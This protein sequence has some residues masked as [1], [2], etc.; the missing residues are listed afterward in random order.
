MTTRNTIN[1][2]FYQ[3]V[4]V[5]AN[6]TPT[7]IK[8][9]FVPNITV[10]GSNTQVQFNNAGNLGASANLTFDNTTNTL[11]ATNI[12]GSGTGITN[13][14][15]NNITGTVANATYAV[16]AGTA[17]TV[18]TNAQPNITSVGILNSLN[19]VGN[20]TA[21]FFIGNV[22][23]NISG[24]LVVPGTNT[25]VIYNQ[26]GSAGASAAFKFDYAANVLT[27][28]GNISATNFSGSGA[29]LTSINGANVSE[30]AN[31]GYA[32]NAGHAGV[33]DSAN[34]VAAGNI[35]GTIN[36][37]TYSGTA[38]AVAGANVSGT[39]AN[40]AYATN[41]GHSVVAD[42]AN[43]VAAGNISGTI[44][45]ATYA[46]TANAVAGG[47]VSGYVANATHATS[48]DSATVAASANS[49][50]VA[51]VSGIGNIAVL[52]LNGNAAQVL[53][54]NGIFATAAS[55]TLSGDGGNIS[56]IQGANVSGAVGQATYADTANAVA[57]ANV[58]GEVANAAYAT[59]AGTA[60]SVS[61]GNVSGDVSGANHANVSDTANS[62]AG[63]NVSGEVATANYASYAGNVTI[64]GQGNI[65]SLGNLTTLTVND[66]NVRT[67][68]I[69]ITPT[70]NVVGL[71]SSNLAMITMNDYGS[72]LSNAQPQNITFIKSR[73]NATTPTAAANSDSPMRLNSHVFNGNTYPRCAG[74]TTSAP[75]A[76]N[77]LYTGSTVAWTP[78]AI[79]FLT[80]NP[81]GNVSSTAGSGSQLNQY[82]FNPYGQL[83]IT[84]GS[85]GAS[86]NHNI[87]IR[88]F[89]SNTTGSGVG[90]TI[91]IMRSRG[92]A[93]SAATILMLDNGDT[94]GGTYF[95]AT[96][97]NASASVTTAASILATVDT[98]YGSITSG[99]PMPSK[100]VLQTSDGSY[101]L[102][103]FVLGGDGNITLPLNTSSINYANGSPYGAGGTATALNSDPANVIISGGSSG[104]VLS[105][106][107]SGNLSWAAGGTATALNSDPANVIISGGSSGQVLST[108]GSGNLSW[109]AGGTPGGS[110]QQVQFNNG[111]AFGG[112]GNLTFNTIG[113][114]N[115]YGKGTLDLEGDSTGG[116]IVGLS[117]GAGDFTVLPQCTFNR[118]TDDHHP[119]T[120]SVY[121]ARGNRAT[122]LAVETND[123]IF[124]QYTSV[125]AGVGYEYTS[126]GSF[127]TQVKTNDGVGNIA[128]TTTYL[129]AAAGSD[130]NI[131]GYTYI[132]LNGN[133]TA[134]NFTLTKYNETV[135]SPGSVSGTLTPD[136]AAGTIYHYTLTGGI[137]INAL[138]NAV[139]GTSMT[140]ILTQDGSGSHTLTSSMK[141]AGGAKTLSTAA[142][143]VDIMSV[144]YDGSTYYATLSKG[145]A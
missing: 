38:N 76:A 9:E 119:L 48:A 124:S 18:T 36:F 45:F 7:S 120:Y 43:A 113:S 95:Q 30:V 11:S 29:S 110:D 128:V 87:T 135:V 20:I 73:G 63:A 10:A 115:I 54:G 61:G 16:S 94:L 112:D 35:S 142:S 25:S 132:N 90:G 51:N 8:T 89:G 12:I 46:G 50:A 77:S 24:N 37:A 74:I 122:P 97:S 4:N 53:Y 75:L 31:A 137:T 67:P 28:I 143:S 108:D 111:G 107:G 2:N 60:Y 56:N 145:Y 116:L 52:N 93:D 69:Q 96:S 34:A 138:G 47:N 144:F 14:L 27:V 117:G 17:G 22:V 33:A 139:A 80:G 13:I 6:G 66:G 3:L 133:V 5:D 91:Q 103:N 39:V 130:F 102:R 71:A 98:T 105:T 106:D 118:W 70:G 64:A 23:G 85:G 1:S 83:A 49:V 62:V 136:A 15:A 19:S 82:T 42:S 58:S 104:Q 26:L 86:T 101:S 41:S 21:P 114:L 79:N 65:T 72:Q 131:E 123:T 59:T 32:T 127:S 121:R 109:A 57:G 81:Y 141:F 129:G 84:Q 44:N 68:K 55:P 100:I 88:S 78:G 40:A 99:Q 92:N 125:Y 134:D 126:A 140:L